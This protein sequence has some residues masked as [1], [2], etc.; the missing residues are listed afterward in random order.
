[1][2]TTSSRGTM[3]HGGTS[4][5]CARTSWGRRATLRRWGDHEQHQALPLGGD[6]SARGDSAVSREAVAASW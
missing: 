6:L 5:V 2:A 1:M 4:R 3:R